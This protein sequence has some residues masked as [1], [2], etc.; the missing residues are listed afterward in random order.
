MTLRPHPL[1]PVPDAK[2]APLG[3]SAF[4]A[5]NPYARDARRVLSRYA[6]I[7]TVRDDANYSI[8][9]KDASKQQA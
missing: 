6:L 5:A 4:A 1:P 2:E 9:E 3:S 8:Q 7:M